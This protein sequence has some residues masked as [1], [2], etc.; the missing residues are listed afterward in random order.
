[1]SMLDKVKHEKFKEG[2]SWRSPAL[3]AYE[4]GDVN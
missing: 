4:K 2:W 1:M 3:E